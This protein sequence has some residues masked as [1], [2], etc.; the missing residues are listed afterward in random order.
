MQDTYNYER[1]LACF[2]YII[3]LGSYKSIPISIKTN[4]I[5][6]HLNIVSSTEYI[7]Y[8]TDVIET[9]LSFNNLLSFSKKRIG[10]ILHASNDGMINNNKIERS[11]SHLSE[12][13]NMREYIISDAHTS[14]FFANKITENFPKPNWLIW[15]QSKIHRLSLN[16]HICK[17]TC[18][19]E[20]IS[21]KPQ[22]FVYIWTWAFHHKKG[23]QGYIVHKIDLKNLSNNITVY[24]F[25]EWSAY[26]KNY[27]KFICKKMN[28]TIGFRKSQFNFVKINNDLN[29]IQ[30][31]MTGWSNISNLYVIQSFCNLLTEIPQKEEKIFTHR[32][33]N[34]TPFLFEAMIKSIMA[35]T[36]DNS[37]QIHSFDPMKQCQEGGIL[38][39]L[40]RE[41]D[42]IIGFYD[43][44]WVISDANQLFLTCCTHSSM[45]IDP[46]KVDIDN[47][48]LEH[49]DWRYLHHNINVKKS[50]VPFPKCCSLETIDACIRILNRR[51]F[52]VQTE[53]NI[54]MPLSRFQRTKFTE[55]VGLY[56][57]EDMFDIDCISCTSLRHQIEWIN[58][59]V[60]C[61]CEHDP[62]NE[63]IIIR[64]IGNIHV[65][66]TISDKFSFEGEGSF[67]YCMGQLIHPYC[68][69]IYSFPDMIK[70]HM[71]SRDKEDFL[72]RISSINHRHGGWSEHVSMECES[73]NVKSFSNIMGIRRSLIKNVLPQLSNVIHVNPKIRITPTFRDRVSIS[74][75][76]GDLYNI[77]TQT[78]LV[79]VYNTDK[80]YV[81]FDIQNAFLEND[82]LK[83]NIQAYLSLGI[84]ENDCQFVFEENKGRAYYTFR[85]ANTPIRISLVSFVEGEIVKIF[86]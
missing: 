35:F 85:N 7:P 20:I 50:I 79:K 36:T 37:P 24:M 34:I 42:I 33:H 43:I 48:S 46:V 65:H 83:M 74:H 8:A 76:K 16:E 64:K 9:Y 69:D 4:D 68:E 72:N 53:V 51:K 59:V 31:I 11:I 49:L 1:A 58:A 78:W 21:L 29:R 77:F 62:E 84:W 86:L 27:I 30:N 41:K 71:F 44:E 26:F 14:F 23:I 56:D 75:E 82:T 45:R 25:E 55:Q 60:P 81:E 61:E 73:D 52:S 47:I 40:T 70:N 63:Q 18:R 6:F 15:S 32:K 19:E 80:L 17:K 67:L 13:Y 57:Y 12:I 66:M 3:S 10:G 39:T 5:F 22:K 54:A 38:L 28:Y 2:F